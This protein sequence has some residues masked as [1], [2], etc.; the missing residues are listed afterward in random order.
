MYIPHLEPKI[1]FEEYNEKGHRFFVVVVVVVIIE[2]KYMYVH[3]YV[4]HAHTTHI[5]T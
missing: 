4:Q 3:V 2:L 5:G 1:I